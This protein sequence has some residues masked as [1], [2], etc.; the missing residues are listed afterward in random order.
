V[1]SGNAAG[2]PRFA[3]VA[4][5]CCGTAPIDSRRGHVL[6]MRAGSFVWQS[7]A[8]DAGRVVRLAVSR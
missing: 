8:E 5:N 4:V 6:W 7:I 2:S 1:S 3:R